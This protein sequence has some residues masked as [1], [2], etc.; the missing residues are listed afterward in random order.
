MA[1]PT[2]DLSVFKVPA[3]GLVVTRTAAGSYSDTT[4]VFTAGSTSTFTANPI[5]AYPSTPR[6]AEQLPE[7][8]RTSEATTFLTR[9]EL[10]PALDTTGQ[11]GDKVAYR[12]VSWLILSVNHFANHGG[13]YVC[14]GVRQYAT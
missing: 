13:F 8:Q 1:E 14:V 5:V 12:G 3:G 4:G 11:I 6:E 10:F 9:V 2:L 7:G